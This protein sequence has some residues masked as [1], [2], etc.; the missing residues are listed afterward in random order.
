MPASLVD[1]LVLAYGFRNDVAGC[2]LA[3]A[4]TGGENVHRAVCLGALLGAS[5]SGGMASL[6]ARLVDGLGESPKVRAEI[7]AFATALGV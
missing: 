3:N 7:D 5:N 1:A 2:L 4:N 6:P